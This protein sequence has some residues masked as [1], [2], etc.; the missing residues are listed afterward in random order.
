MAADFESRQ[1]LACEALGRRPVDAFEHYRLKPRDRNL[2]SSGVEC[3]RE[4][5][6]GEDGKKA[7]RERRSSWR[8]LV[9]PYEICGG[10]YRDRTD[11][12]HGVNVALYQLS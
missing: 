5:R 3:V 6:S 8:W 7:K 1:S 12:I 9:F 2:D 4:Q 10:S 11:D